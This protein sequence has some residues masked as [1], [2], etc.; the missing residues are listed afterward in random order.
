MEAFTTES[1]SANKALALGTHTLLILRTPFVFIKQPKTSWNCVKE[2]DE[3]PV[4][5]REGVGKS[6]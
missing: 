1:S 5:N 4:P 2:A 3:L 6:D